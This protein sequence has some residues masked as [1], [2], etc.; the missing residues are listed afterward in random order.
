MSKLP[1]PS[2]AKH[3]RRRAALVFKIAVEYYGWSVY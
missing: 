2:L 1:A 3:P